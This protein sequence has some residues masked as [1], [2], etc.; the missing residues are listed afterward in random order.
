MS[1]VR[2]FV[3]CKKG[4]LKDADNY[5][6]PKGFF[7]K[8][9]RP[10]IDVNAA[11]MLGETALHIAA[12]NG[13]AEI[14][15]FLI[16]NGAD[17][18]V[19]RGYG[20]TALIEAVAD[21]HTEI[22]KILIEN[23]AHF[24]NLMDGRAMLHVAT[25]W[26]N[27]EIVKLLIE[28]GADINAI[29]KDGKT[30]LQIAARKK[31]HVIEKLLIEN[32]ADINAIDKDGETALQI[33]ARKK[34]HVIGKLPIEEEKTRKYALNHKLECPAFWSGSD[35]KDGEETRT[36]QMLGNDFKGDLQKFPDFDLAWLNAA[37]PPPAALEAHDKENLG[38]LLK[39]I[40]SSI[41]K[42][43]LLSQVACHYMWD[44]DSENAFK[45][46]IAFLLARDLPDMDA[47]PGFQ[48]YYFLNRAFQLASGGKTLSHKLS[49]L[50]GRY[51]LTSEDECADSCAVE[52][53]KSRLIE[54]A[55]KALQNDG[56]YILKN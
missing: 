39:G 52:I 50:A 37:L 20:R 4:K 47:G 18:N 46:A 56:N 25:D 29:D 30:A 44:R 7:T 40:E 24:N 16:E 17:I 49:D 33:V 10:H 32:G 36:E 8:L 42:S 48:C 12:K 2:F 22:A 43:F 53:S 23:D 41:R 14:V 26:G 3:A 1:Q 5:L 27:I 11:M 19:K 34:N 13:H 6:N 55:K 51:E 28:K 45:Y 9:I 15:K 31:N 35:L 38:L 54:E 21:G